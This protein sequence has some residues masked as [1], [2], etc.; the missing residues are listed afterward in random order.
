MHPLT[1][2]HVI[3]SAALA[4]VALGA[5]L[6]GTFSAWQWRHSRG[7]FLAMAIGSAGCLAV[8][9]HAASSAARAGGVAGITPAA[10]ALLSGATVP[11][12]LLALRAAFL[13]EEQRARADLAAAPEN[14]VT[15][16][17]S[18]RQLLG[19]MVPALARCRRQGAAASIL[20][21]ELDDLPRIEEAR[22]PEAARELL[23]DFAALLRQ[24]IRLGDLPGHAA[25]QRLAVFLPGASPQ[26]ADIVAARLQAAA[27]KG[28]ASPALDGSRLTLS[29]GI[30]EVGEGTPWA[31]LE[32]ALSG[33]EAALRQARQQGGACRAFAAPPPPRSAG[34]RS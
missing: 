31:V 4:I 19:Q 16:L 29:I 15:G 33:A 1:L 3:L 26:Q 22:G 28:L 27:A 7:R 21:A 23:R 32:E 17:P 8:A 34:A 14:A 24:T 6:I 12:L 5:G 25:A 30:A 20:V 9:F 18:R 2:L 13:R 10:L 11:F